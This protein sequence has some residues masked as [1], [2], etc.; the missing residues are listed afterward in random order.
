MKRLSGKYNR[1]AGCV[2]FCAVILL[3]SSCSSMTSTSSIAVDV[4]D[5][6]ALLPIKNLSD[7]ADADAQA[8]SIIETRLRTR[9]IGTVD[10]YT[11]MQ[12]VSL[13]QLL[14]TDEE[15]R[16]SQEWAR[17]A[18]YRYGLTGTILE[19]QYKS[20]S[21]REP[22]VGLSLKLIDLSTD[23]VVWQA[24]A[25]RTGWGYSSLPGVAD[26]VIKNMLKN[27]QLVSASR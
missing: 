10:T 16:Q 13:R 6:W 8:L 19:W 21:D 9:G 20:G 12:R 26:G 24:N 5:H 1:F 3:G 27:V 4:S 7:T 14:D 25:A 17:R 15:M 22:S 23:E 2:L 18:G 11:P